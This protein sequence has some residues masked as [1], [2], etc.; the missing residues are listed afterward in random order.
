[1][2]GTL[3]VGNANY[4]V[5]ISNA[6]NNTVGGTT[7]AA[8][9]LIS[10]N[11]RSGVLISGS[12]ATGNTLEGNKI[13]TDAA[14]SVALGNTLYGVYISNASANSV[15]GSGNGSANT[16]AFNG[17]DG[18]YVASGNNNAIWTNSIHSNSGLG[19][20]LSPNGVTPNDA[21]DSDAGANNL[22]N[23][24]VIDSATV[25]SGTTAIAGTLNS[26][27]NTTFR[28]EFYASS[29]SDPSG[30]GEGE[31]Y[32]GTQDVTTDANG[33]ASFTFNYTGDLTGQAITATATDPANNT[34]EFSQ[35]VIA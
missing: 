19:I 2:G 32:L 29:A 35:A 12:G 11:D 31:V 16:I 18:V 17:A 5:L 20:D 30:F 22:Q 34:S 4:G 9:N 27:A 25:A 6:P 24:P 15:G 14:G 28:L 23:F 7:A 21:G 3:D 13:G 33:D 10:G 26:L 8:G 1:M